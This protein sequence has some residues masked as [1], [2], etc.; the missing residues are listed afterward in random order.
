[1]T[2]GL[3]L[4]ST[5]TG[6]GPLRHLLPLR[7]IGRLVTGDKG[8]LVLRSV[9]SPRT[10]A[11]TI[12]WYMSRVTGKLPLWLR[13]CAIRAIALLVRSRTARAWG[14]STAY[15]G[16]AADSVETAVTAASTRAAAACLHAAAAD[17]GNWLLLVTPALTA[18][19][20]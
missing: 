5:M 10:S 7:S 18:G 3:T 12:R 15:M 19:S 1:M 16:E 4:N 20:R 13:Y 14:S 9:A 2:R 8:G 11:S 17:A 6:R